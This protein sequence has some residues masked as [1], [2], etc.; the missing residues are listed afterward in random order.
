MSL[1]ARLTLL[2]IA[3]VAVSMVTLATLEFNSVVSSLLQLA[4]DSAT[5]TAQLVRLHIQERTDEVTE[6]QGRS[7]I[8]LAEAQRLWTSTIENDKYLNELIIRTLAKVKGIAEVSVADE[9]G[10]ILNSTNSER[11]GKLLVP[12]LTLDALKRLAPLDRVLAIKGGRIDYETRQQLGLPGSTKPLF[13]VQV[14]TSSVLL[15]DS[16][17]APLY[18]LIRISIT[19]LV[20]ATML[21]WWTS[22]LALRPLE[23]L[24]ATIDRIARGESDAH[25]RLQSAREVAVVEA[26]LRVLGEQVRDAQAGAR[27]LRGSVEQLLARLEDVTL[28]FGE[29]G[30]VR[31]CSEPA[32]RLL[33]RARPE[34]LGKTLAELFPHDTQAGRLLEQALAERRTLSEVRV[35]WGPAEDAEPMLLSLDYLGEGP[36]AQGGGLVVRLRD[37]KGREQLETE[38]ELATRLTAINRLT[39]GVAHEIKNPLNSIAIRLE[40]LKA[41]M[42]EAPEAEPELRVIEQE[43]NRLDRVVRTFLDF[44]KPVDLKAAELDFVQLTESVLTLVRPEAQRLGISVDFVPRVAPVLVLGDA[45]LLRQ[46]VLNVVRNAMEA[47]STGGRVTVIMVSGTREVVLSVADTGPGIPPEARDKVFQLYYSTKEGGSG[48]G[49]AMAYR[50]FQLHGG[51]IEIDAAPGGGALVRMRLPATRKGGLA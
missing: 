28:M 40:L 42:S 35:E 48:I 5:M 37:I 13:T 14:L 4:V 47:C 41:R 23:A 19:T 12:R 31:M 22:R 7:D 20:I 49:L 16:I 1:K 34:I 10:R 36:T 17:R 32:E 50:A 33:R 24:E 8:S 11:R 6:A 25:I 15:W 46:A 27:S 26:K 44:A 38:I 45:D 51:T 3:L 21:T 43:I 2:M 29:D 30:T 18:G 9:G 39:G